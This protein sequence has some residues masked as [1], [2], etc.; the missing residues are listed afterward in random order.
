[1]EYQPEHNGTV[2][3][4]FLSSLP[5]IVHLSLLYCALSPQHFWRI[6]VGHLYSSYSIAFIIWS[7]NRLKRFPWIKWRSRTSMRI[8]F[9]LRSLLVIRIICIYSI[10]TFILNRILGF[11]N[12]G[13]CIL[14]M[15]EKKVEVNRIL[16]KG[17]DDYVYTAWTTNELVL[18]TLFDDSCWSKW[19][20]LRVW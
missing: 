9:I 10:S 18:F 12:G 17:Q 4:F 3:F 2:L 1:M 6:N 15:I 13:L 20:S 16:W 8:S 14:N 7:P 11:N 5:A 19:P